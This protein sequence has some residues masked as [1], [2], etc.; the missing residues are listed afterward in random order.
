MVSDQRSDLR[1]N[2]FRGSVASANR[3]WIRTVRARTCNRARRRS[4][5]GADLRTD[6]LPTQR[7]HKQAAAL[8]RS[9]ARKT[10]IFNSALDCILTID[11]EGRITEFNPAAERTFGYRR[12]EVVGR[13]LADVVIPPSLR[14]QHRQGFGALSLIVPANCGSEP[15]W[16][17]APACV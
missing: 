10:A 3:R 13:Q 11:H 4:G 2:Q 1:R 12:N 7:T 14:E 6:D 8:S 5:D 17:K 16:R 9:E 15:K